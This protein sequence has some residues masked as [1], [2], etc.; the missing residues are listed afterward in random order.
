MP[1]A[2]PNTSITP[3]Y[4]QG[5]YKAVR[6]AQAGC[7]P[8]TA[9][10]LDTA[11]TLALA[12]PN[13]FPVTPPPSGVIFSDRFHDP[14]IAVPLQST[15]AQYAITRRMESAIWE[16]MAYKSG[17]I[18]ITNGRFTLRDKDKSYAFLV[19][20]N[21]IFANFGDQALHVRWDVTAHN[22]AR[23]R[24]SL[25]ITPYGDEDLIGPD[26]WNNLTT[27]RPFQ[28]YTGVAVDCGEKQWQVAHFDPRSTNANKG[29]RGTHHT[30][31]GEE[32]RA[33]A[34][35]L[36]NQPGYTAKE[37]GY[38]ADFDKM[39]RFDYYLTK[40]GI[41]VFEAVEAYPGAGNPNRGSLKL[42]FTFGLP[43]TWSIAQV[44]PGQWFYHHE[45]ETARP[46]PTAPVGSDAYK[47]GYLW[48]CAA[49]NPQQR[50]NHF[51]DLY[52]DRDP[53]QWGFFEMSIE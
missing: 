18:D 19:S 26:M 48:Q 27:C 32:F 37:N 17:D 29:L 46:D 1:T 36:P 13:L 30:V 35:V 33:S 42:D 31:S 43:L 10:A 52:P 11:E 4:L 50:E 9:S 45:A 53:R 22:T 12:D 23:R 20:C 40:T 8:F 7:T 25:F 41:Q 28:Q 16:V 51:L 21:S 49:V 34:T 5:L 2:N 3:E 24:Q 44:M 38:D 15:D 39:H 6:D 47:G 14:F